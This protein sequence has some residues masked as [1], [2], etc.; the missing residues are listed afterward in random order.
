MPSIL[1]PILTRQS[2]TSPISGS[3][4]AFSMMVSPLASTAAISA[5]W[6]APTETLSKAMWAPFRP[7]LRL[8]DHIA[9][10]DGDLGAELLHGQEMHVDGPRADGAAAGQRHLGLAA[11]ASSGPSTQKLARILETSS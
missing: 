4:A 11:A 10:L 1:A 5:A 8:G 7:F 6:V 9:A 2:A 3:R